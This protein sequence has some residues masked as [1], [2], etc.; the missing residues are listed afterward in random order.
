[1]H[2]TAENGHLGSSLTKKQRDLVRE[3][4]EIYDLLCIDFYDIGAYDKEERTVRLELMRNMVVRAEVIMKYVLVDEFLNGEL[5]DHF[6]GRKRSYPNLWKTKK[7]KYFN[8]HLLEELS[9]MQKLRYVK[10]IRKLPKSVCADVERLNALRNGIAHAFFPENLRKSQ[11]VWKG[12]NIFSLEA[13]KALEEDIRAVTDFP[14]SF[15]GSFN[16]VLQMFGEGFCG[17]LKLRTAL[18][19][20]I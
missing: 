3:L 4:R 5:C 14:R 6:F 11:P 15:S 9:L 18:F 16:E 8:Y 10:S 2:N 7:F 12:K 19:H 20:G 17:A 1:M 13:L